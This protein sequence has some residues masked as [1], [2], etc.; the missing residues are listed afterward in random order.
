MRK[1]FHFA[2]KKNVQLVEGIVKRMQTDHNRAQSLINVPW[3]AMDILLKN[4]VEATKQMT[5][6]EARHF[7]IQ[8]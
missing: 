4:R 6:T 5:Q 3:M 2:L 8:E 1:R 7:V